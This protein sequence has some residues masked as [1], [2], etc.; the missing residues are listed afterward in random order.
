[1]PYASKD[2]RNENSYIRNKALRLKCIK[3]L[4]NKCKLCGTS[5]VHILCFH[6]KN[7]KEKEFKF[8]KRHG[9]KFDN[10]KKELDKCEL[11]CH[12]CHHKL[13]YNDGKIL[14][15][16]ALQSRKVKQ[17]LL[18]LK[19]TSECSLCGYNN[20]IGCLDFHH[21]N[22]DIK[23]FALVTVCC[24]G[25]KTID[26]IIKNDKIMNELQKCVVICKN[27]HIKIHTDIKKYN[28]YNDKIISLAQTYVEKQEKLS[29][30]NLI[31]LFNSGLSPQQIADRVKLN[32]NTISDRLVRLNKK[33]LVKY[34]VTEK[35]IKC[36]DDD[37]IKFIK[38]KNQTAIEFCKIHNMTLSSLYE[39]IRSVE[40]KYN[41]K[42]QRDIKNAKKFTDDDLIY[43]LKNDKGIKEISEIYNV[44]QCSVWERIN[45][46]IKTNTITRVSHGLYRCVNV[47]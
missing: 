19:G 33:G 39:R 31:K 23:E 7:P 32:R 35:V 14:C 12:N 25:F 22:S 41:V 5:D 15:N 45:K 6:H 11:L 26:N 43:Q 28:I 21:L 18:D 20:C 29:S 8:S 4:G 13:H 17:M 9:M 46:L 24:Q 47:T 2:K 40:K 30:K 42:F 16:K 44:K 36:T 27:C 38:F 34:I 3:Y 1:M 10:Y 37:V